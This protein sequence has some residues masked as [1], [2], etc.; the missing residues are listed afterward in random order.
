M[1]YGQLIDSVIKPILEDMDAYSKEAEDLL[2]M[3]AAHESRNGYYLHQ[4]NGPAMGLYQMEPRTHD[5]II[6]FLERDR[7][8]LLSKLLN[9]TPRI[10]PDL[11]AGNM[12]YA[13]F[14][15][16]AFFLR[17]PEG[18]PSEPILAAR[19]LKKMWNTEKGKATFFDY[20]EAF[21]VWTI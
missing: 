15:A 9:W 18:I 5:D 6:D 16:R 3:I 8:E 17:F 14:M 12:Y 11:M 13:T 7:A 1:N 2:V 4:V 10:N 20:L 19:Y 21:N